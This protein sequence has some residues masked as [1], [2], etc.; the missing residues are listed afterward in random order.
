MGI[1]QF[2]LGTSVPP[3]CAAA[4]RLSPHTTAAPPPGRFLASPVE[5]RDGSAAGRSAGGGG[6]GGTSASPEETG[7]KST[8][9]SGDGVGVNPA[10]RPGPGPGTPAISTG[11]LSQGASGSRP[12][13]QAKGPLWW[14]FGP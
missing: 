3:L 2:P 12:N 1:L 13:R 10:A 11:H 14:A 6:T 9:P 7:L 5:T 8:P 4:P